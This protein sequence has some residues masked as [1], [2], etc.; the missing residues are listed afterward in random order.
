M[1]LSPYMVEL[2]NIGVVF[3]TV[4]TW[5]CLQV[6]SKGSNASLNNHEIPFPH[7]LFVTH[8]VCL[9]IRA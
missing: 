2:Q 3:S 1:L 4:N 7:L 5:V 6:F 9:V 8:A